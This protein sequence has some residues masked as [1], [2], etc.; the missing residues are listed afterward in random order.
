MVSKRRKHVSEPP[1]IK[2]PAGQVI[3]S[4]QGEKLLFKLQNGRPGTVEEFALE[5]FNKHGEWSGV[6]S[7]S[8]MFTSLFGCLF[9]DI[10]FSD[11]PGVFPTAFQAAPLDL[12][13]DAFF[14]DRKE[15]VLKRLEL[16][17]A[18]IDWSC[19]RIVQ[20]YSEHHGEVVI[21]MSWG[22]KMMTSQHTISIARHWVPSPSPSSC[23]NLLRIIDTP[24][25][26]CQI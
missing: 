15:F 16:I 22:L 8:S 26:V 17:S 21:G 10:L 19:K 2:I 14:E 23:V 25:R 6:H 18:N 3:S 11:W 12:R 24:P 9:W 4:G 7:E 1:S 13:T 20:I 5:Y